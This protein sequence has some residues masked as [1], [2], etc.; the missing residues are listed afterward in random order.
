MT[1]GLSTAAVATSGSG[2]GPVSTAVSVG[3]DGCLAVAFLARTAGTYSLSVLSVA[4]GEPLPGSPLQVRC[5]LHNGPL[6]S[7]WLS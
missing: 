2:P 5:N 6:H 1:D 4:S 3:A 7:C